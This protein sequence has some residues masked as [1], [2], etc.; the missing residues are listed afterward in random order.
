MLPYLKIGQ[1]LVL[2]GHGGV[3][4]QSRGPAP[5]LGSAHALHRACLNVH[6][7][8]F[9]F[10]YIGVFPNTRVPTHI[11]QVLLEGEAV[12]VPTRVLWRVAVTMQPS[13]AFAASTHNVLL[14]RRSASRVPLP[15]GWGVGC[16]WS[17]K[18][19]SLR[20]RWPAAVAARPWRAYSTLMRRSGLM[21]Q[22]QRVKSQF[23]GYLL[24]FQVGDFYELYG[25]DASKL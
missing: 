21:T 20:Q 2:I 6:S 16:C 24:L 14:C 19:F 4:L 8:H 23:P 22:F 5:A 7:Q 17:I 10:H 13:R 18:D 9:A 12:V 1:H 25:D 11:V 3:A 15:G